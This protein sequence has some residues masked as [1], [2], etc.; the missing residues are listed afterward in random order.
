[1]IDKRIDVMSEENIDELIAA[2]I[3]DP[4]T[5]YASALAAKQN[6]LRFSNEGMSLKTKKVLCSLWA[7]DIAQLTKY[8]MEQITQSRLDD[9]EIH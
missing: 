6:Y 9:E 5:V 2:I 4:I 8:L 3:E 1:M 7:D